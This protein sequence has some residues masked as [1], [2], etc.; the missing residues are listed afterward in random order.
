MRIKGKNRDFQNKLTYMSLPALLKNIGFYT[1]MVSPFRERHSAWW[2]YA[3]FNEVYNPGKSGLERADE[4]VPQ[5]VYNFYKRKN[6]GFVQFIPVIEPYEEYN[7]SH[8][9]SLNPKEYGY[10]L[11]VSLLHLFEFEEFFSFSFFQRILNKFNRFFHLR[12]DNIF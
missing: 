12:Y 2:F 6:F 8:P 9:Y 11:K 10:F 7:I 4:V 5:R 3:G 1:V